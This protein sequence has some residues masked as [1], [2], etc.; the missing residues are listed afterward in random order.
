MSLGCTSR[1]CACSNKQGSRYI[2]EVLVPCIVIFAHGSQ[3]QKYGWNTHSLRCQLWCS[4]HNCTM[5][6]Y[7]L[8]PIEPSICPWLHSHYATVTI[9]VFPPFALSIFCRFYRIPFTTHMKKCIPHVVQW[10]FMVKW[11]DHTCVILT[12]NVNNNLPLV[13]SSHRWSITCVYM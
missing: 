1:K 13:V 6:T 10:I 4:C 9:T 11:S 7:K 8:N 2:M 12:T 5:Y 3:L